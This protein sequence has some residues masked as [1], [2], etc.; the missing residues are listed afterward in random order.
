MWHHYIPLTML[1]NVR[2]LPGSG[3]QKVEVLSNIAGEVQLVGILYMG[4]IG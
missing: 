4:S 1:D 2:G 3:A